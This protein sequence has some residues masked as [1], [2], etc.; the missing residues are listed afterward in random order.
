MNKES[1]IEVEYDTKTKEIVGKTTIRTQQVRKCIITSQ[2]M[3][4]N[5]SGGQGKWGKWLLPALNAC[6]TGMMMMMMMPYQK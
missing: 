4:I 6:G 2:N 3:G 1:Q 5:G